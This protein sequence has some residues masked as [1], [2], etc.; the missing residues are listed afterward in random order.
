MSGR[1]LPRC[2]RTPDSTTSERKAEK[3]EYETKACGS[4]T[5]LQLLRAWNMSYAGFAHRPCQNACSTEKNLVFF[6]I[7]YP[8]TVLHTIFVLL[9][10]GFTALEACRLQSIE[11]VELLR[12][13]AAF[14]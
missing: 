14:N 1:S 4:R 9:T 6:H 3:R 10:T 8:E 11:V 2:F 12:A 7:C 13:G 5:L